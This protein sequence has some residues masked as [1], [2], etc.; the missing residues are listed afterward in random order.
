MRNM[1]FSLT[2]Q[3]LLDGSKTVTRRLGWKFLKP[4]DHVMAVRK[5]RGIPKGE[6]VQRLAELEIVSARR[7]RLF[8]ITADEVRS[9]GFLG[10]SPAAFVAMFC[11]AMKCQP[12]TEVTRVEFRKVPKQGEK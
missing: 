3:Q 2:E 4:G 5:V 12:A 10:I 1:S 8:E 9:E 7:E 11:D 6:K